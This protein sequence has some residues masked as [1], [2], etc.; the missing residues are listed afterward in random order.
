MHYTSLLSFKTTKTAIFAL[1][2]SAI[3]FVIIAQFTNLDVKIED[4]YYNAQTQQFMWKNSWFAK[5]F[6]HVYVKKFI[7][8]FGVL[9]IA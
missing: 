7:I 8:M 9:C 2:V 5:Q 3:L 1:L 6:M 4:Y